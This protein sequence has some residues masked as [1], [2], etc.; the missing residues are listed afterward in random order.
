MTM[1]EL[2][3]G[4]VVTNMPTVS[5]DGANGV[6]SSAAAGR[7]AGSALFLPAVMLCIG[8]SYL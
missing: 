5:N 3:T 2:G 1:E 7:M 6:A 4:G 8:F